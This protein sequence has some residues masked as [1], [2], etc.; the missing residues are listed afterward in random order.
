MLPGKMSEIEDYSQDYA[1]L[2]R[3]ATSYRWKSDI[4]S[5]IVGER[6]VHGR[7]IYQYSA[8]QV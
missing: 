3:V 1:S 5:L 7:R 4:N 8:D 6:D 2:A